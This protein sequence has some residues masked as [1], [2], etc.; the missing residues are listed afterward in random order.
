MFDINSIYSR[1][2][3]ICFKERV[4]EMS[5]MLHILIFIIHCIMH[6]LNAGL[7]FWGNVGEHNSQIFFKNNVKKALFSYLFYNCI[8]GT[9][10]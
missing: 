8:V 5:E 7:F 6:E 10:H 9:L 2:K 1:C 3:T 4:S